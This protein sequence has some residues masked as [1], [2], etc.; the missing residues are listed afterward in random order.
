MQ[1]FTHSYMQSFTHSYMQSF[2]H[3]YMQSFTHSYMQSITDSYMQSFPHSYMQSF[4]HSYMQSFTHS[5]MQSFTDSYM[6]SFTHS[7]MQSFTHSYTQSFTHSYMQSFTHSCLCS[8]KR[9]S[10]R[11]H[12]SILVRTR[13]IESDFSNMFTI[14]RPPS[15]LLC[16][17]LPCKPPPCRP[18]T[19]YANIESTPLSDTSFMMNQLI[20]L[21]N[22][23]Y[24][25]YKCLKAVT[26]QYFP[27][28]I[29]PPSFPVEIHTADLA[30]YSESI[31]LYFAW[32]LPDLARQHDRRAVCPWIARTVYRL[33]TAG[34]EDASRPFCDRFGLVKKGQR[35]NFIS[36]FNRACHA[37]D[38][39]TSRSHLCIYMSRT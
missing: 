5:Y 31:E 4:T 28:C 26:N 3:S 21:F 7:Y 33:H 19:L 12:S 22:R 6:Q 36:L 20:Y 11:K 35:R 27:L 25:C 39:I 24:L 30:R 9:Y 32:P 18:P 29:Y 2:T 13:E 1:S 23:Q 15:L 37:F 38:V 16:Y 17:H 8:F 14:I 34:L 10:S